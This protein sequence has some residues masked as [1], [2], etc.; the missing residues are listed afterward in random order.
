M[1]YWSASTNSA[2]AASTARLP[3]ARLMTRMTPY[4]NDSPQ[5]I[6]A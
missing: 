5:A 2:N 6:S 4:M 1:P 3:W